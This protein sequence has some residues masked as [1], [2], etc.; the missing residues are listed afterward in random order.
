MEKVYIL[1]K[2]K[3]YEDEPNISIEDVQIVGAYTDH[4][5]ARNHAEW[6][7]SELANHDNLM[8]NRGNDLE[9]VCSVD[10]ADWDKYEVLHVINCDDY[11]TIDIE[12][13]TTEL[14]A[15]VE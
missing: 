9:D 13:K 14:N 10:H 1:T 4:I 2:T 3:W 6:L 12:I 8:H 5:K 11:S 7:A 15:E